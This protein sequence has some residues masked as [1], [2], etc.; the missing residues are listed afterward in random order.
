MYNLKLILRLNAASCLIFGALFVAAPDLVAAFLGAAPPLLLRIVGAVLF[1]NGLHLS[2][3]SMRTP[4]PKVEL[5]YFVAGDASWVLLTVLL[6]VL[7]VWITTTPGIAA[8]IAV[9]AMV[10][11]FGLL[12]AL[13]AKGRPA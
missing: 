7:G 13:A 4:L 3:A 11:A 9:A 12:Q 10:G 6:L 5:Y 8:A 1:L 2:W